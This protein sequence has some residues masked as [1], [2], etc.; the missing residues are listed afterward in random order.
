MKSELKARRRHEN[1]LQVSKA[2]CEVGL[3]ELSVCSYAAEYDG[4]SVKKY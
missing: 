2:S 4:N 1:S 3:D